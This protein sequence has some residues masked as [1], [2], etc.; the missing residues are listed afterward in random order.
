VIPVGGSYLAANNT[1]TT[2]YGLGN[3]GGA[4]AATPDATWTSDL[5]DG[6]G[7]ALFKSST[8]FDGS[9]RLDSA[10]FSGSPALYREGAGLSPAS[11]ISANGEWVFV[12]KAPFPTGSSLDSGNN[13][14]DFLFVSTDAGIYST[15]QSA[16]G[17]P[18]PQNLA[19]PWSA[20]LIVNL[21]DPAVG[22]NAAP[23]RIQVGNYHYFRRKITNNTGS[24]ITRLKYRIVDLSTLYGVG[25]NVGGQAD[26]RG[27]TTTDVVITL[28]DTTTPNAKGLTLEAPAIA[29]SA[30]GKGAG[31]NSSF[32]LDLTSVGGSLAN[33]ASIYVNIGFRNVKGG[34]FYFAMIPEIL[35]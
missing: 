20:N 31:Y 34:T 18:G 27:I 9:T 21:A 3:Y 8:T 25:Y 29:Y 4:N 30:T 12:R 17:S 6:S 7:V 11:G 5:C 22:A 2:G 10:G 16:L 33:G 15:V 24:A 19:S 35:N 32:T 23:N 13:A 1:P 26:W 14:S 28:T